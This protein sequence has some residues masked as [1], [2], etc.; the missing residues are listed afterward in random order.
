MRGLRYQRDTRPHSCVALEPPPHLAYGMGPWIERLF[1]FIEMIGITAL[2]ASIFGPVY[3]AF[4]AF[5]VGL[6]SAMAS[7]YLVLPAYEYCRNAVNEGGTVRSRVVGVLL[8]G[9]LFLVVEVLI[10]YNVVLTTASLINAK[11]NPPVKATA[12]P[13]TSAGNRAVRGQTTVANP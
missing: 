6:L 10:S 4:A 12:A 5:A 2:I 13:T 8:T 7:I 1:R 3:P 11:I 9:A